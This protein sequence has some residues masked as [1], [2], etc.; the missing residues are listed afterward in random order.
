VSRAAPGSLPWRLPGFGIDDLRFRVVRLAPVSVGHAALD[1]CVEGL[2]EGA[3]HELRTLSGPSWSWSNAPQLLCHGRI[4]EVRLEAEKALKPDPG[5][6]AARRV[7]QS[8]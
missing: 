1:F 2:P 4:D 3:A 5:H 6:E 8:L 7:L